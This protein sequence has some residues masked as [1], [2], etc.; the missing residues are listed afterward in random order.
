MSSFMRPLSA[1]S[2]IVAGALAI[3]HPA[4]AQQ[5]IKIGVPTS[6]QLQV[7]RDTQ[8]AAKLAAEEINA[9][10]GVLGRKLEIVVADETGRADDRRRDSRFT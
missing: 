6:V 5:T 10:G 8:N 3:T 4:I 2:L 1:A 9:K 7:G